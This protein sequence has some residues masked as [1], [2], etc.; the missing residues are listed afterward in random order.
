MLS[1][2]YE[3]QHRNDSALYY[4]KYAMGTKDSMSSFTKVQQIQSIAFKEEMKEREQRQQAELQQ[5]KYRGR[6]KI[7]IVLGVAVTLLSIAL[8]LWR[9]NRH[10][11]KAN[12]LLQ[13]KNTQIEQT[14]VQ[15]RTTQTQLI[16]SEKMASLGELTAGIAHEIQNPLNFVNNFSEVNTELVDEAE[17]G[18][19]QRKY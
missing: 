17:D 2:V 6:V 4:Y 13:K 11:Q 9:N 15:L 16:Q 8:T 10:K 18:I 5:T 12:A 1:E 14:L 7:L 3:K 19:E